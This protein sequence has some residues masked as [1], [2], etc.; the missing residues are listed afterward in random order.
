M[1]LTSQFEG[2]YA[3]FHCDGPITEEKP[4]QIECA[5]VVSEVKEDANIPSPWILRE[6]ESGK[7]LKSI[8]KGSYDH[9]ESGYRGIFEIM[10]IR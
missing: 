2:P 8:F 1:N 6:L 3:V 7:V 4:T 9:L 10:K 5:F